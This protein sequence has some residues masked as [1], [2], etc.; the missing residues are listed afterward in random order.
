MSDGEYV[1]IKDV[2]TPR[3]ETIDG[4]STVAEALDRM[5]T[6]KI[7]SLIIERRG[8]FDEF[9]LL[10]VQDIATH[11]VEPDR[12]P[13]RISAYEIMT[14][15]VLSLDAKMNIR[16]AIRLLTRLGLVRALVLDHG[17]AVGVVTLRDMV[18]RYT[19]HAH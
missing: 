19:E 7:S 13:D 11:V 6:K 10:T 4:L 18:F 8:E 14:K 1:A 12:S 3:V 16:Y 2:M 5:R 17:D 15:P 9:G